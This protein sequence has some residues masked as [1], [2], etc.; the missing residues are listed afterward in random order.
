M[1]VIGITG[2]IG[3]GKSTATEYFR[4]RGV[5]CIDAD[6]LSRKVTEANGLAIPE[7][8][9]FLGAKAVDVTGALNRRYVAEKVFSDRTRLDKLTAIIHR[10]V[11]SEIA[12]ELDKE[13][14]K[15][16]KLVVLDVPIPVQ[17]GFLDKCNQVWVIS[18]SDDVR[19]KRL[20]GRGMDKEDAL[21]RIRMQMTKEEY[22]N[23]ADIVIKNDGTKE[24]LIS[25][26]DAYVEKELLER[27]IRI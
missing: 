8:E 25:S 6:E 14:E 23:L 4:T 18:C 13:A 26:L 1:F 16:I 22:E 20:V 5:V 24:D 27:G 21:R 15:G 9:S 3:S 2:G 12:I 7:I 11:L 10:Y 19:V 17:N